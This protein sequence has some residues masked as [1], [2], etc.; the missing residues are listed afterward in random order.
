MEGNSSP[1]IKGATKDTY[2][3]PGHDGVYE[4]LRVQHEIIKANMGGKLVLAPIDFANS[5]HAVLDSATADGHWSADLASSIHPGTKLVGTDIAPQHSFVNKPFNL[6]LNVHSIFDSWPKEYLDSFDLVH[7]RF[8]LPVCNDNQSVDTIKEFACVKAGGYIRLHYGDMETVVERSDRVAM[9]KFRDM[10]ARGVEHNGAQSEPWTKI[11]QR[12]KEAGAEHIEETTVVNECRPLVANQMQSERAISV[13][14][15]LLDGAQVLFSNYKQLK[16]QHV[17]GHVGSSL[18]DVNS[19]SLSMPLTIL[20]WSVLQSRMRQFTPYTAGAFFIDL[21]LSCGVTLVATTVYSSSP[22]LLNALLILPAMVIF[23]TSSPA[24]SRQSVARPPKK[25]NDRD[26]GSLDPLPI[27]PFITNYRGSMMVI[28]CIAILAVDF[29]VF[30][31]RF[32]KVENWGTSLMDMGVGSFVFAN[33]VVSVRSSLKTE[34]GKLPPFSKRLIASLRHALPLVVLGTIRLISVKGLDYAE[35]VTEYGVHWNFFFTLGF[36]PPFV[37]IFQSFFALVPSYAI[38]SCVLAA[39]YE[40]ALDQTNLGAFIL[41]AERTNIF[42]KNREGIFSFCGY[43]AIFLAGQSLGTYALA[44]Q[45]P[46]PKNASIKIWLR[47]SILGKLITSSILWTVLFYLS[48]SFYGFG[49][50]VSR[51]L[52]NLPYF[53]WVCS[54]NNCQVAI[55]CA[56]ETVLFPNIHKATTNEEERKRCR[57]ATSTILYAVN[58]NGL[59]VFLL[60]NL[61]TGLV[62]MTIPT[63]HMGVLSTMTTLIGYITAIAGLAVVL[64]RIDVSIKL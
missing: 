42:S 52:A 59:A 9:T 16:T 34:I 1:E 39:I 17:S 18:S 38:L 47:R 11:T 63:L 14:L 55:C 22:W 50:G 41:T 43:L 7:Q 58:R 8:V 26:Q 21:L 44:R 27:K 64:D 36:L 4:R 51:R 12:L 37:A 30:P 45:Q 53:L 6:E 25:S 57:E 23:L 5:T 31:R 15:A 13:L 24:T 40:V 46:L 49:L 35:H 28:T 29:R 54:F 33:G 2:K 19:V 56:I 60:A 20:L 48:I 61:L 3:R 32:A 62:N 10:M